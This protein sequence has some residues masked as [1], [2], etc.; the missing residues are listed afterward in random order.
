MSAKSDLWVC[1]ES[2][3]DGT[4]AVVVGRGG[5]TGGAPE[6]LGEIKSVAEQ[7]PFMPQPEFTTVRAG[8]IEL[9]ATVIRPRDFD[10][11]KKYPVLDAVYGGPGHGV[12]SGNPRAY[13][14]QQW[15][16]DQGFIVVAIDA[17]GTPGRGRAFERATKGNLIDIPLSEHAAALAALCATRPEMD[18]S[19]VGVY[20]WSFGGYFTV[21]ATERRPDVFKAGVAVAPVADWRDY[22]THYTERYMGLPEANKAGYD[23]ASA[24]TYAKDLSVPLLIMHGTADDN[25]YT[26]NSLRLT[27]ALF[28]AGKPFEFVPLSGFTHAVNEPAALS[29]LWERAATFFGRHLGGVK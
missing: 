19:R 24:L 14:L 1:N 12:V 16:A 18:V 3:A 5:L 29:R 26:I 15:F 17:R 22:D 9:N 13:L 27:D 6:I 2:Y 4:S 25:V 23:A 20:G 8:E 10:R 11:S 21:L 28:R 7:P